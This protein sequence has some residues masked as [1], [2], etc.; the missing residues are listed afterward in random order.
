MGFSEG[1]GEKRNTS[2]FVLKV[3]AQLA[4]LNS[5]DQVVGVQQSLLIQSDFH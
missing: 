2:T 1:S 5:P 4:L 3:S